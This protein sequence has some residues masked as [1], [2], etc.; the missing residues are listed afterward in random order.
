MMIDFEKL[1]NGDDNLFII[2]IIGRLSEKEYRVAFPQIESDLGAHSKL[3]VLF[4]LQELKGWDPGSRW[5]SLRFDSRHPTEIHRVGVVTSYRWERWIRS[6]C[7]PL[8]CPVRS[9]EN[10]EAALQWL[11]ETTESTGLEI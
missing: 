6:A 4:D 7:R 5:K 10:S 8:S 1:K 2:R 9:F 3:R 11:M